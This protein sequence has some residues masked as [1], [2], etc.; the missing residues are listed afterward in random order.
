MVLLAG[1]MR[2][3]THLIFTHSMEISLISSESFDGVVKCGLTSPWLELEKH[4]KRGTLK[5]IGISNFSIK[6]LEALY[7][8]AEIKPMN[9]QIELH[10]YHRRREIVDLCKKLNISVTSY[11]TLGSP[12]RFEDFRKL[13][14]NRGE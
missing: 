1:K 13:N 6:Q 9:L 2:S 5:S 4:Y 14:P 8:Q 7:E 11:A 10:I 3:K 12:G